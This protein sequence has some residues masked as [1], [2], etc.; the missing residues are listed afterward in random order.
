[1]PCHSPR[2]AESGNSSDPEGKIK[3]YTGC[4]KYLY[5]SWNAN[6]HSSIL[7]SQTCLKSMKLV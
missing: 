6:E 3:I 5:K 4:K 1:M 7:K 2:I